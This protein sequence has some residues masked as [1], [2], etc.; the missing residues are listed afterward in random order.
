M[1]IRIFMIF[2][3]GSIAIQGQTMPASAL[4]HSMVSSFN[5]GLGDG[6]EG[7]RLAM[8]DITGKDLILYIS[9]IDAEILSETPGAADNL[10][11]LLHT[12]FKEDL[13]AIMFT[14]MFNNPEVL[15]VF[16]RAGFE[17]LSV[18]FITQDGEYILA[19]IKLLSTDTYIDVSF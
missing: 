18:V 11:R 13:G 19:T 1:N 10:D 16:V 7:T 2:M 15:H 17:T 9:T 14:T 8:A 12:S 6:L 5:A 3:L 4:Q